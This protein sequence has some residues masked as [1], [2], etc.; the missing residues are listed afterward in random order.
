MRFVDND[1][2]GVFFLRFEH[3]FDMLHF[4]HL[5]PS[6]IR[7]FTLNQAYLVAKGGLR[8]LAIADPFYLHGG[9]L[10]DNDSTKILREYVET[11]MVKNKDKETILLP[12]F[13]K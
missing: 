4:K 8:S 1:P 2:G 13:L 5:D 9:M 3:I 12:F 10:D 6:I 11:F 7:L